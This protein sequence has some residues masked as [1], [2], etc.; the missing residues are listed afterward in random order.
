MRRMAVFV[1]AVFVCGCLSQQAEIKPDDAKM[2]AL[3]ADAV[4]QGPTTSE[5]PTT[6][7]QP[8][9]AEEEPSTTQT[10][11][12]SSSTVASS[13]TTSTLLRT[14]E[15]KAIEN[16]MGQRDCDKGYCNQTGMTCHYFQGTLL[17][18]GRCVCMLRN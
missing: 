16:A 7:I 15:C 4:G 1:L 5:A 11:Q 12:T 14:I 2:D 13:T 18:A 17:K 3:F 8:L 10:S 6:T 9:V